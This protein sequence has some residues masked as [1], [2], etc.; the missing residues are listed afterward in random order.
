MV[1]FPLAEPIANIG[2][3]L[4]QSKQLI[5]SRRPLSTWCFRPVLASHNMISAASD[6]II[7]KRSPSESQPSPQHTL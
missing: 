7:A 2:L 4:D 1:K 3:D 6:E 5:V